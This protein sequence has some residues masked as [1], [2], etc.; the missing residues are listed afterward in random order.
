MQKIDFQTTECLLYDN[1]N[2]GASP[3]TNNADYFAFFLSLGKLN[4]RQVTLLLF[5]TN[6]DALELKKLG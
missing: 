4:L 2:R 1:Q 5:P 6:S 3:Q